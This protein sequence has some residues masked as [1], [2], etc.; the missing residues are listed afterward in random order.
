MDKI[1]EL[2]GKEKIV[3]L[4]AYDY[5]T[6]KIMDEIGIDVILVGDSLGMVVLGHKDT[7][8]VTLQDVLHHTKAVA[9]GVRNSIVVGDM[10]IHTYDNP[11]QAVENAKK[12]IEA[13]AHAVKIEGNKPDV[14]KALVDE[15]IPVMGHLGLLPQTA[16]EYKVQGKDEDSANK[17]YNDA[18]EVDKLG[19]FS[20]VLECIPKDLAKKIT[21]SVNTPTIGIGAGPHCTGQVLVLHDMLG[22]CDDF[23]PKFAKKYVCLNKYIKRA[24][25][26]YKEEVLTGKFPDDEHCYK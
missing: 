17:I 1:A 7:K 26:Q 14:I 13:G 8:S 2:K 3:M 20:I 16:A 21:E 24:I 6:A 4:T 22:L 5:P 9:R 15:S 25:H 12:F 10:P 23:S 18:L 19:V 11:E